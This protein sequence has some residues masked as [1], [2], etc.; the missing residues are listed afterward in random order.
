MRGITLIEIVVA[1]AL[2]VLLLVTTA[3]VIKSMQQKKK[4]FADRLD[5]QAWRIELAER[6]REDF[7]RSKEIRIGTNSLE[8]LGLSG[9]DPQS[10]EFTHALVHVRWLLKKE[11]GYDILLRIETPHGSLEELLVKPRV[12]P[13]AVGITDISIGTFTGLETET[14]DEVYTIAAS[15]YREDEPGHWTTMPKVLRLIV[16]GEKNMVLVDELIYR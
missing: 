9:T 3:G 4:V 11:D 2:S 16:H 7:L 15:R 12:K 14:N 13:M 1:L 6:L 8:F 10:H 5:V